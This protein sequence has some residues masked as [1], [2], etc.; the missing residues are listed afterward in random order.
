M[1]IGLGARGTAMAGA[2]IATAD[3][4]S[5]A[6]WNP[7]CLVRVPGTQVQ[8]SGMQWFADILY[9]AGVV[10]HEIA[11]VGTFSA[12]FAML[13]SGDMDVTTVAHPEGTGETFSCNDMVAGI[14]FSRM[15]TDRF[16][17]GM[18]V[19]YVREQWDDISA[20]GIAVDIGTL[21]DTGFKTLRIGMTI[22]HFGG[23]LTPGGEYTT[24]YSGG[25]STEVYEPYS[26]PMVFKLGM[27][28]DIINRGP[29]FLTVEIDGIHPNDNVEELGIGTEYWYNNMFAL[30]G[31][32][33]INTDEEGLTAGAGFNIPVSGKTISLDYAYADWNRLDMVHQASLGFAF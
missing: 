30:R 28:M 7:A 26:M 16:S 11:G 2:F 33:C 10:S 13:Q 8:F 31:G 23:E 3:D 6:F 15:L 4:P 32:Y 9:G 17:A 29:H 14:S 25:D 19:K 22:Q 24:Y 12:Q 1:K 21:Y 20:G 27:A 5:A 18:T